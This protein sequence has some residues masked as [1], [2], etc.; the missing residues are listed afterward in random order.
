[1]SPTKNTKK[2]TTCNPERNKKQKMKRYIFSHVLT[3]NIQKKPTKA[4]SDDEE[5]SRKKVDFE[6]VPSDL[7]DFDG[8]DSEE[9]A[10]MLAMGKKLMDKK[11]RSEVIDASFNR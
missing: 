5:E 8:Y 1:M 4:D 3:Y 11:K 6:V 10:E 7:P 2:M 9:R